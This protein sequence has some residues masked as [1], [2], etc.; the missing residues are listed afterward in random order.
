MSRRGSEVE[1]PPC[2]A[3]VFPGLEE[4]TADEITRDLAGQVRKTGPGYVVFRV[5]PLDRHVLSLRT[6]EDVFLF[7]WG[8]DEL[9]HRAADLDKIEQ[10]TRREPDWGNL[11]RLHHTVHPRPKG[12]PT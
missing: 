3:L 8:T 4:V 9:T 1:L 7:A 11:L 5:E 6:T 10:W 12:R 2:Y